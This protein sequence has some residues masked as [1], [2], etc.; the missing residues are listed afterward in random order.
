MTSVWTSARHPIGPSFFFFVLSPFK[1]VSGRS[2]DLGETLNEVTNGE[3]PHRGPTP[4]FIHAYTIFDRKGSP[5]IYRV[6]R[7]LICICVFCNF[8]SDPQKKFP[9][10]RYYRKHFPRKNLLHSK[11][12]LTYILDTKI[13]RFCFCSFTTL[14]LSFRNKTVYNLLLVLHRILTPW[15]L[16]GVFIS[17][18]RTNVLNKNENF[19]NAGSGN[20]W[21]SR[22][23]IPSKKNHCFL[24]AKNHELPRKHK[25]IANPQ[26]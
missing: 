4:S 26:K 15:V 11:Y 2:F 24:I 13:P 8:S 16:F 23:L 5:F 10:I 6:A 20:F 21:K 25:K 9:Q 7:V 12:S 18:A 19:I 22:K 1:T 3:A 17:V 14:S